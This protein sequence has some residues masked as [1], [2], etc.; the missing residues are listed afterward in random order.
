M[1]PRRSTSQTWK[2]FVRNHLSGAIAIDFLTVPTVTFNVVYIYFV[3]LLERRRVLHVNVTSYP[4]AEW[5]AQQ[6][7]EAIGDDIVPTYLIRDRDGIYGRA[8]DARVR[9]VG[10]EQHTIEPR[11]SWQNG[12]AERWVG[13]LRRELLDHVV[14]LGEHHSLRL[15]RQYVAYYNSDRPPMSLDGDAPDGRAV[16]PP[17]AGRVVAIP[18][19]GGIHHRYSRAA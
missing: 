14:V 16:E 1:R 11:S 18:K 4:Y 17:T 10:I 8:F 19:V 6:I 5:A 7:V 2:T 12:F 15:V 13:S 9:N 3:L